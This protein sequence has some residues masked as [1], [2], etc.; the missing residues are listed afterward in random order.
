MAVDTLVEGNASSAATALF[1]SDEVS[2][3]IVQMIESV[4]PSV[5]QVQSRGHGGGAGVIWRTD[6]AVVTNFHVIAGARGPI[7]VQLPDGRTFEAKVVNENPALDLALLKVDGEDLPA[8]PV[9]DSTQLRVGELVFAIGHPWGHKGVVTAGIVSAVGSVPIPRTGREAQYIRSDVKVAPGNSGGPLL[10]AQGAVV[11]ITAMIFGGDLT[12]AIPSHVASDWVAGL[13]SR[14]IYLGVGLQPVELQGG[15]PDR[16]PV[17]ALM[18]VALE[19][20]GPAQKAGVLVGDVL[21]EAGG[22]PLDDPGA[23]LGALSRR[24]VG[25]RLSLRLLRAGSTR[26]IDVELGAPEQ[27]S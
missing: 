27:E 12:V 19:P 18:V 5:V 23:L 11:G 20:D 14:R 2:S 25:D 15:R 1:V 7:E 26:E 4:G 3:E 13:P 6:G 21:L 8:A 17:E 9:A 16:R 24:Q 22:E 10:N